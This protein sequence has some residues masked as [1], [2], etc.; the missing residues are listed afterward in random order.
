VALISLIAN[1]PFEHD[2]CTYAEGDGLAL[3]PLSA[4]LLLHKRHVRLAPPKAAAPPVKRRRYRRKVAD[5]APVDGLYA[6]KDLRAE[7]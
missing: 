4:V 6:R 7:P 1:R 3:P 5:E 2:G